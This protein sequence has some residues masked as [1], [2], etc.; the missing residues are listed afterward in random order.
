LITNIQKFRDKLAAG[1]LCLGTGITCTDLAI[2]E[3]LAQSVDFFWIDLEHNPIGIESLL[4]HLVAARAGGAPA[5][6]RVPGSEVSVLKRVL[7]TGAEGII[8]PQVRSAEEVRQV[9]SACRYPPLGTRGWGPRRP[10]NYGRLTQ[11]ETVDAANKGLFVTVQIEHVDAV[12]EIDDIL[13]VDGLDSIALG[14]YDLSGSMGKLGQIAHAEVRSVIQTVID[15]THRAG[16]YVGY[17][18]DT[19]AERA[20]EA[21]RIG[22]DWIQCGSDFG[23]MIRTAEQLFSEI[24]KGL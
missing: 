20:I 22:A 6:V 7:D 15:K 19:N 3:S 18:T 1:S 5:L 16:L 14:P 4:G 13:S 2:T 10:S 24:R 17:G 11:Q 8:V 23:Y 21:A 9:V 12:A